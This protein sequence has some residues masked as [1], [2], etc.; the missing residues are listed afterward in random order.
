MQASDQ[1]RS[2]GRGFHMRHR[3]VLVTLPLLP[4]L[5][6]L[7]ACLSSAKISE[8][9]PP[10]A[11]EPVSAPEQKS[12]PLLLGIP[13]GEHEDVL[14]EISSLR[15]AIRLTPDRIELR[16]KLADRLARIG[17]LDAALDESRAAMAQNPPDAQA[18]MQLGVLLMAR[19]DWKSAAVAL[20]DAVRI[21]PGLTQAHYNLGSVHYA[22]GNVN[23]AMQSYQEAIALQPHFPD[24]QYRLALLL[25]LANHEPEAAQ[26]MGEAAIGGV[27]QA[28]YFLGNAYKQGQGV[29]KNLAH[30]IAWWAKAATLGHQPAVDAL[31][32]LRRH[33]LGAEQ[34]E[35]RRAEIL[36]A[37]HRYRHQL[38]A[39]YPHLTRQ[40]PDESLG[41]T[42]LHNDQSTDGLTALL[43]EAYTLSETAQAEL[44]RLYENGTETGLAPYD[45]R[46]LSC[47]DVTAAD[48]FPY[49]KKMLARIYA[50]GLGVEE[51]HTKARTAL[52]GLSKQDAQA[53][54]GELGLR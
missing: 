37:F 29:E 26:L 18:H 12:A 14:M 20:K 30:A 1:I 2:E 25:K 10:S 3:S 44:A 33:A 31:S 6:L 48:G 47:F 23:A 53:L 40:D 46:I 17:D 41:I 28:Q 27:P 32:K 19:Q 36:D 5:A 52:N 22:L 8:D 42:L 7:S 39:E 11:V 34:P 16:L 51:D 13:K 38:W 21:D 49:A 54:I 43:A 4:F 24:A 50:K 15:N 45:R 35:R 9:I